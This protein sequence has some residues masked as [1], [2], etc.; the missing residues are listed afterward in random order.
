M[1]HVSFYPRWSVEYDYDYI[2]DCAVSGCD[3]ICRCGR[4]ENLHVTKASPNVGDVIIAESYEDKRGAVR[5]REYNLST[6]ERYCID[7]LLRVFK[8]YDH[9]LYTPQCGA[10]VLWRGD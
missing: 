10:R 1:Y 9:T 4:Y 3:S 2:R 5:K 7:R 8:A 6:I